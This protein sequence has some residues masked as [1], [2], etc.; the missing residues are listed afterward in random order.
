[1]LEPKPDEQPIDILQADNRAHEGRASFLEHHEFFGIGPVV[2]D[3]FEDGLCRLGSW[4]IERPLHHMPKAQQE[5][6]ARF[7]NSEEFSSRLLHL[8]EVQPRISLPQPIDRFIGCQSLLEEAS[9]N[10][11]IQRRKLGH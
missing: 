7:E 11:L 3:S 4:I 1:M 10:I 9:K 8:L 5:A 6:L 2:R